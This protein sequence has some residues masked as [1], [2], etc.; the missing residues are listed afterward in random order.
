MI[1][2]GVSQGCSLGTGVQVEKPTVTLSLFG[3]HWRVNQTFKCQSRNISRQTAEAGYLRSRPCHF[4][5]GLWRVAPSSL[6]LFPTVYSNTAAKIFFVSKNQILFLVKILQ[7]TTTLLGLS[8]PALSL[9]APLFLHVPNTVYTLLSRRHT[10]EV[11]GYELCCVLRQPRY[12]QWGSNSGPPACCT[13]SL[14]F[15]S[16]FTL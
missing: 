16:V 11:T 2:L 7:Q 4:L 8:P 6:V 12:R 1:E 14:P 13:N 10:H 3:R 9:P 15:N 5:P